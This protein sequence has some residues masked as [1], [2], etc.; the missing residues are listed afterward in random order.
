[1]HKNDLSGNFTDATGIVNQKVRPT[2]FYMLCLSVTLDI[3]V[4]VAYNHVDELTK[5]YK[6]IREAIAVE[7]GK[8]Y[9]QAERMAAVVDVEPL[10]YVLGRGT[11]QMLLLTQ[12][13][14]GIG[15]IWLFPF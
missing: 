3:H 7:F 4:V 10:E 2:H 8:V 9:Q 12:W 15:L 14:G 13:R 5:F 1:M 6:A 11:D